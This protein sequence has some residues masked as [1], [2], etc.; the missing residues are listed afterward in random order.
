MSINTKT[1]LIPTSVFLTGVSS[2]ISVTEEMR[3]Y[4]KKKVT[5]LKE[6]ANGFF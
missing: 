4:E 6:R 2:T 5:F 3:K 1:N